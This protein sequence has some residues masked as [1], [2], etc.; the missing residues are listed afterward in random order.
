MVLTL[1]F[2]DSDKNR[3]M[4]SSVTLESQDLIWNKQNVFF[5]RPQ[6]IVKSIPSKCYQIASW[7]IREDPQ[8][9]FIRKIRE[10]RLTTRSCGQGPKTK[11]RTKWKPTQAEQRFSS[12]QLSPQWHYGVRMSDMVRWPAGSDRYPPTNERDRYNFKANLSSN[13]QIRC[14]QT[15]YN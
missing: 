1:F 2:L 8:K 14:Q 7:N 15:G 9:H 10:F 6:L 5:Q 13:V 11:K 3:A 12:V 4:L